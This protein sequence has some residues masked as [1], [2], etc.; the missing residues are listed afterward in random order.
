LNIKRPATGRLGRRAT[1]LLTVVATLAIAVPAT[2]FAAHQFTDVPDTQPFH[3][4]ISKIAD[5]GITSGCGGGNF[6]PSTTVTRDQ[7]AAFMSRGF[8]VSGAVSNNGTIVGTEPNLLEMTFRTP[9]TTGG[10]GYLLVTVSSASVAQSTDCPCTVI[11]QL[12]VNGAYAQGFNVTSLVAENSPFIFGSGSFQDMSGSWVVE[13][14]TNSNVALAYEV[15]GGGNTAESE[16]TFLGTMTATYSP[17]SSGGVNT[18][19]VSSA[20]DS[21]KEILPGN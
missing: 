4:D 12:T 18:V 1:V 7:M 8:G 6:C 16:I 19:N 14:P 13:V 10:T 11:G 9:G 17:F 21:L 3:T 2:V 20:V 15:L 5:A